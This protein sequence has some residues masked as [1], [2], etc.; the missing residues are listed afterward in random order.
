[1]NHIV[2]IAAFLMMALL[3]VSPALA[4]NGAETGNTSGSTTSA[5]ATGPNTTAAAAPTIP[6]NLLLAVGAGLTVIG[7]GFGISRIGASAVESIAR[8]PEMAGAIQMAM[9]ISAA[10][11]EGATFFALI[12]CF[13][14][15]SR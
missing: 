3:V 12:I 14:L 11:I 1:M 9:L 2:R 6:S 4:D 7:G 5:S 13:M 8:Q 15:L 10:L